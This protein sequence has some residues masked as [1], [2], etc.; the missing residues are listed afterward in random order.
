[1]KKSWRGFTPTLAAFWDVSDMKLR[2][3]LFPVAILLAF[4]LVSPRSEAVS[5]TDIN[6][7]IGKQVLNQD[8][9]QVIDTFLAEAIDELVKTRDF[10]KIA[11]TRSV[12]LS[13]KSGPAQYNEQ[14]SQSARKYIAE[15][16]QKALTLPEDRQKKV[17]VNLLI[18]IDGLQDPEL[19]D[20]SLDLVG[21]N[22]ATIVRYW[23]VHS[24]SNPAIV[25]KLRTGGDEGIRRAGEIANTFTDIVDTSS[26]EVLALMAR[27][28]AQINMSQAERLLV[29]VADARIEAYNTWNVEYE[30]IDSTI[31]KTLA[32]KI[33]NTAGPDQNAAAQRFGQLL[34][35]VMQRMI[36]GADRLTQKQRQHLASVLIEIETRELGRLLGAP[37]GAIKRAIENKDYAALQQQYD[38]L[39]GQ[40]S[41]PG[42]LVNQLNFNFGQDAAGQPRTSPIPLPDPPARTATA[43]S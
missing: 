34:H 26:P 40:G 12:I 35:C 13:K 15:G 33:G 5:Q 4:V 39:F 2:W 36:K 7:V 27:F 16:L 10:T 23:I 3:A 1:M 42:Q 32:D 17:L 9:L 8:D 43:T 37:Q 38:V 19:A 14:F 28:A 11:Q 29:A 20:L 18:L 25:A 31:L 21:K 22:D 6:R 41:A 24:L 30:L